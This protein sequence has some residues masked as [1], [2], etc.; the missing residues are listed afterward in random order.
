MILKEKPRL[1]GAI[2][3]T[4]LRMIFIAG[5]A[6]CHSA[7]KV[8]NLMIMKISKGKHCL[9]MNSMSPEQNWMT[10]KK[11]QAMKTK[12]IITIAWAGTTTMI[13]KKINPDARI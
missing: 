10:R 11:K 6:G 7:K 1:Y 9:E 13:W 3:N 4:V 2:R 8:M 5:K 12:K